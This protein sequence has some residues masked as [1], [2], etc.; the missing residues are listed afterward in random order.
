MT[1][2]TPNADIAPTTDTEMP[3]STDIV[4]FIYSTTQANMD[5]VAQMIDGAEMPWISSK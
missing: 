1:Y 4:S 3:E 2:L 5:V